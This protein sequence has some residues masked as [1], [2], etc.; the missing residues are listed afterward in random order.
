MAEQLNNDDTIKIELTK[1]EWAEVLKAMR[2]RE[3]SI[4]VVGGVAIDARRK[5]EKQI[6]EV[7]NGQS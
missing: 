5:I 6:I 4:G 3:F 1:R 7:T 2:M